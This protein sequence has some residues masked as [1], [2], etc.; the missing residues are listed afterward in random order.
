MK[1]S[2]STI[3]AINKIPP[4]DLLLHGVLR[5]VERKPDEYICPSCGNGSG[6]NA[7]GIKFKDFGSHVG[8]KCQRCGEKFNPLKLCAIAYN[9]DAKNNFQALVEKICNNFNIPLTY[10]DAKPIEW[11]KSKPTAQ[12]P[13]PTATKSTTD[14]KELE[15]IHADL[16][17]DENT[18][19]EFVDD[20][21]GGFWRGLPTDLLIKFGCR[22]IPNWTP[23]KSRATKKFSTPTPRIIIPSSNDNYL[24]RLTCSIEKFDDTAQ[25]FIK[26]KLHAGQKT[27]FNPD[28]LRHDVA[29]VVEGEVDAMTIEYAGY[30][31]CAVGGADSYIIVADTLKLL[32]IKPKIIVLFDSD[33]TGRKF[34]PI[35]QT[36]LFDVGCSSTFKFLTDEN[37]KLDVNDI[38][39]TQ[40][41]N[42]LRARLDSIVGSAR[43]DFEYFE[44]D[45]FS[46]DDAL[47]Y[48]SGLLSDLANAR[49]L[50]KFC[51]ADVRWISDEERWLIYQKT[52]VW[53]P[54]S[55]KNSSLYPFTAAFADK[56]LINA[57]HAGQEIKK[58][59]FGVA[60]K[61]QDRDKTNAAITLLKGCSSILI[62][63]A[64][65]DNHPEL[66]NTLN[67]VIELPTKKLYPADPSLYLTQQISVP[68]DPRADSPLVSKFFREVMPDDQTRAGLLRWLGYCLTGS[69]REEKFAIWLGSGANGKGVL[70]RITSA[71]LKDY[72]AALPQGALLLNRNIDGNAHT[73]ALCSLINTR[74]AICEELPQ[75][76]TLNAALLKTL[77][78]GD[79]QKIRPMYHD[80]IEVTPTAKIN[81]SSNFVPK[82]ENVD[83]GGIERR[84][85]IMPFTQIFT[86]DKADSHLKEKLLLPENL[87]ALLRLLVDE[88]AA[89]YDFGLIISD[90][91]KAATRENLAANDF[92]ADFL[93]EFYDVGEGKGEVPRAVLLS[94][95]R[96]K[97]IQAHRFTDRDLCQMIEKRGVRYVRSNH[98]YLFKGIRLLTDDD[99][100]HS[101]DEDF[102]GTPID[103][104][105]IPF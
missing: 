45:L 2:Q 86:G 53:L 41:L 7:T 47:F 95:L 12:V 21:C 25:K 104:N 66:A 59:A 64:D 52:G 18:L 68:Y 72:A 50:E 101:E 24:A 80:F 27:L 67:G 32:D 38:L 87:R 92:V 44:K 4:D 22:Y 75:N 49:R 42:D 97:C 23:P 5:L 36:K 100:T 98:G 60:N 48:F 28:A 34:A 6:E 8:G 89:W 103:Q 90:A 35:L 78:G 102:T 70:T 74:F 51:A 77:T 29:F 91:M 61:F 57:R 55:D 71:L 13:K 39:T 43:L 33:E 69:V 20:Q 94:K 84:F 93:D 1:I 88:A 26:P 73:A 56:L 17:A 79:V 105:D 30:P 10:D 14:P 96:E 54:G 82:F 58:L 65:L 63:Q 46:K 15:L 99:F 37:S 62:K 81:M 76:F 9:L 3:E 31:A 83:D 11:K 16:A 85:L 19:I 40:G